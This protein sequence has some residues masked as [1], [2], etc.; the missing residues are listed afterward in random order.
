MQKSKR[1]KACLVS[2][3][4]S[5]LFL[6]NAAPNLDM[7][8][9]WTIEKGKMRNVERGEGWWWWSRRLFVVGV[10]VG[11][12]VGGGW[13]VLCEIFV[14]EKWVKGNCKNTCRIT[15]VLYSH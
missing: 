11:G 14:I 13:L 6:G 8:R 4:L 7:M 9:V 15:F 5:L 10:G 2:F 1:T 12:G 3:S